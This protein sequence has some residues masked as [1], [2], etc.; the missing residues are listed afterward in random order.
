MA[1]PA[2]EAQ[3]TGDT[4]APRPSK[5]RFKSKRRHRNGDEDDRDDPNHR[6]KRRRHSDD[7]SSS[8]RTH[9]HRS[10]RHHHSRRSHRSHRSSD[11]AHADDPSAYDDSYDANARS[12]GYLSP[13]A[14]FRESL[15][16]ALADDEGAAYWESVYG[17]P[18]HTYPRD[19][20][21]GGGGGELEGMDDEEYARHV[22][23]K[24]WERTHQ[25]VVEER[26]R[27]EEEA[28]RRRAEERRREREGGEEQTRG[29]DWSSRK[30]KVE[31]AGSEDRAE[32]IA[33]RERSRR[34]WEEYQKRWEVLR[35]KPPTVDDVEERGLAHIIPWPVPS[36]RLRHVNASE[37]ES[38]LRDSL[39]SKGRGLETAT[40]LKT[41]RVRWHPDKMQ[42]RFGHLGINDRVMKAVTSVFQ[43]V[44]KMWNESR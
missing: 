11:H 28:E 42:Q 21:G 35:D 27:R 34:A 32:E 19:Q 14:A 26:R 37:V 38:F 44:D 31:R 10:H 23:A 13:G 8:S 3:E 41:E 43:V 1:A 15:F 30:V 25:H 9:R 18:I 36:G 22:R 39:P 20:D 12:A 5:F 16:D 17:Q 24:M 29:R 7:E 40:T 33:R 2:T 6:H 4:S